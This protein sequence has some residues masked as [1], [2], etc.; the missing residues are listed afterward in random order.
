MGPLC[1]AKFSSR[2]K[3]SPNNDSNLILNNCNDFDLFYSFHTENESYSYVLLDLKKC[4]FITK[5]RLFNS[6][7]RAHDYF[8]SIK[9]EYGENVE[10]LKILSTFELDKVLE[11]EL[12]KNISFRFLKLTLLDKNYFHLKKI[13][14][15]VNLDLYVDDILPCVESHKS[16]LLELYSEL[17]KVLGK[18]FYGQIEDD[19]I[20]F[21]LDKDNGYFEYCL[22]YDKNQFFS[23]F[24]RVNRNKFELVEFT[25]FLVNFSFIYNLQMRIDSNCFYLSF[26]DTDNL[27]E[28]IYNFHN[29]RF[30][31]D[32]LRSICY[33]FSGKTNFTPSYMDNYLSPFRLTLSKKCLII[34]SNLVRKVGFA[35]RIRGILS[36]VQVCRELNIDYYINFTAPFNLNKYL[37]YQT[38]PEY[39]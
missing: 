18:N 24:L 20:V 1:K 5:I 14:L 19:L 30:G 11:F 3:H 31:Y 28:K 32:Y 36:V 23:F 17:L 4:Y 39:I 7:H 15:F 38:A 6:M 22:S 37:I 16:Y 9:F 26:I 25:M 34:D 8:I 12:D 13:E 27:I 35:D 2:S 33:C 29:V 10:Q 21:L